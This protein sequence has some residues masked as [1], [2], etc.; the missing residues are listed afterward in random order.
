MK[1]KRR[2]LKVPFPKHRSQIVVCVWNT[3]K[4]LNR[5]REANKKLNKKLKKTVRSA[6]IP[7]FILTLIY[8]VAVAL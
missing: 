4:R 8:A 1:K 2:F 5:M 6:H 3:K 7:K